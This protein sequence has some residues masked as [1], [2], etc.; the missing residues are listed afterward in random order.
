MRALL[1]AVGLAAALVTAGCGTAREAAV[2]AA[3]A[4]ATS[5][6]ACRV[7]DEDMFGRRYCRVRYKYGDGS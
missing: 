3:P 7:W 5:G 2:V 1:I 6:P 4:G